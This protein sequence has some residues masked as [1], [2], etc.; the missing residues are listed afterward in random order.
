MDIFVGP[1]VGEVD[2]PGV[3][4]HV[5]EGVEDVCEILNGEIFGEVFPP[6]DGPVHEIG[7]GSKAVAAAH[8]DVDGSL[9]AG[10][11]G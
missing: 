11:E 9:N 4:S 7:Y 2:F 6:V 1:E 10:C 5:G 3:R 8:F